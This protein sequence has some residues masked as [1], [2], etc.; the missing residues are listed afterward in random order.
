MDKKTLVSDDIS[1]GKKL[2]QILDRSIFKVDSAIWFYFTEFNEWRLIL[3]SEYV[4]NKGP[5]E[6]YSYIQK[7]IETINKKTPIK[8]KLSDISLMGPDDKLINFL[9]KLIITTAPKQ[10]AEVRL[11]DIVLITTPIDD[12]LIYRITQHNEDDGAMFHIDAEQ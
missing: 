3:A 11:T 7:K 4:D 6:A 10:I 12:M 1:D 8:I 9:R 2:L 5:K